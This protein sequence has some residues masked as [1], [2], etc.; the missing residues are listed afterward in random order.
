MV[1]CFDEGNAVNQGRIPEQ[2]VMDV[3][4][5]LQR[6][7]DPDKARNGLLNVE[8]SIF[9][10]GTFLVKGVDLAKKV[11][12]R[13]RLINIIKEHELTEIAERAYERHGSLKLGLE[14]KLVGVN[15]DFRGAADSVAAKANALENQ[16]GGG[17]I[18]DLNRE[19]LLS[20]FTSMGEDFERQV[21]RVLSD[22]NEPNPKGDV[23]ASDEAKKIG[24]VLFKYQRGMLQRKNQAGAYVQL[25]AGRVVSQSHDPGKMVKRQAEWMN[26]IRDK[27]D[28]ARMG[29]E[30]E[31]QEK[32]LELAYNAI[33]TGVREPSVKQ[34]DDIAEAFK[35]PQNLAKRESAHGV[36][37]FKDADA[38][39]DYNKEFGTNSLREAY[40]N[41]LQS[42]ARAIALLENFG[43]NPEAML[44]RVVDRL[45][46]K[47][48]NDSNARDA[49]AEMRGEKRGAFR[50]D[51][52][53]AEVTGSV[54]IGATTTMAQVNTN[55]RS[56]QTMAKLGG[57]WISALSDV[58]F[59]ST[60]RIYQGRSVVDAWGDAFSAAFVGLNN[61]E[62]KEMADRLLVGLEGQLGDFFQRYDVTDGASGKISS[63]MGIFFKLN[64]LQPWTRANKRG[65]SLMLANDFGKLAKTKFA[66]LPDAQKRLFRIYNIDENNWNAARAIV[67]NDAQGRPYVMP[68]KIEDQA[69]REAFQLLL[70][71]E[72]EYTVPSPGERE[73]G[74]LRQGLQANTVEGQ[75]IRFITQ[76][77]SFGAT[78]FTKVLGRQIYGYGNKGLVDAAKNGLGA[79]IG[80]INAIVGTTVLGYFIMQAK[81]VLRGRE[82]R[83]NTPETFFA[84]MLQGGAL[85][86]YGDFLFAEANR[87]GG[88]ALETVA[89]PT[90]GTASDVADLLLKY[91][92]VAF[93]GDENV[94]G[95]TI[96]L[97]KSNTP[98]ANLFYTKQVMDYLIWYQLQEI[99][100]PGYLE[101]AERR[102]MSATDQ[103]YLL[104]PSD[105][106]A[107]GG[108]FR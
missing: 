7:R 92:N 25:K 75:A 38:W 40:L 108:G 20:R 70:N 59:M 31:R 21:A 57:S 14:A 42:G 46:Q 18:N 63:A 105:I 61:A 64:L 104:R 5:E 27:L 91:R 16:Y 23:K 103:D 45:S 69:T 82:P 80:L 30:P 47:Y 44:G 4:Q 97:I 86:I 35:G 19:G 48:K 3:V 107:T 39:Y 33:V 65:V 89:G 73:R 29:I 56:L 11:E 72:A 13:N 54:N 96:R 94:G 51:N 50:L 77:K 66:D 95:D 24:K 17:I 79:N 83:P 2:E 84:A 74:I 10:T 62:R 78:V 15:S 26:Y 87:Y 68:D 43:T 102:S 12:K 32:F 76:F 71:N 60:N 55:I 101:R 52:Y 37:V 90:I 22:L 9:E 6:A 100:N 93:G 99:V 98:F 88:G 34:S 1:K 53:M 41:D 81:E 36:F 49:I 106:V 8:N 85:G 28:F 67:E 58:A